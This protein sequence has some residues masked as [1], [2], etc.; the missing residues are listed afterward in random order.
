M[1]KKRK[2]LNWIIGISIAFLIIGIG[3][4][5]AVYQLFEAEK[6]SLAAPSAKDQA[7][8]QFLGTIGETAR[9]VA[10]NHD[11]YASVMIA[12][13]SLESHFGTSALGSSPN[14]NLYGIKGQYDKQSVQFD[15]QEDDGKGN[16]STVQAN[17]RKYPSY[18]ASM[19]DYANLLATGTSWDPTIYKEAF[20]TNARTYLEATNALTGTYATDS[21]YEDKLNALIAQYHLDAYDTVVTKKTVEA[22]FFDNVEDLSETYH[23]EPTL[24]RQWNHLKTNE[25][26]KGD[27]II[28]YI[29]VTN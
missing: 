14:F 13:A 17:F 21:S 10:A 18:E 19:D 12:Q 4:A 25:L 3:A 5:V 28:L 15:T 27:K 23:I 1:K 24:I 11:L 22:G 20:K 9:E 6:T 26:K 2:L 16:M 29:P 7:R 8:E